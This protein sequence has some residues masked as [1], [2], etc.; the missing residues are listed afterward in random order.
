MD[1]KIKDIGRITSG[2]YAKSVAGGDVYCLQG[3]DFN[4]YRQLIGNVK[5]TAF[6]D[7]TIEKHFLDHGD[8]LIAVKGFD[9][10]A[11]TYKNEVTPA[12]ASSMFMVLRHIDT[13]K[14]LPDFVTWYINHPYTQS[15]LSTAAKGTSIQSINKKTIEHLKIPLPS[16][17]K[18]HLIVEAALLLKEERAIGEALRILKDKLIN[19]QLYKAITQ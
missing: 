18:Q 17:K 16:I 8:V 4:S 6:K 7:A 10:F 1:I 19:Q 5:P 2:L 13:S 9:Y 12:V 11:F 3:R 14:A 15:Y